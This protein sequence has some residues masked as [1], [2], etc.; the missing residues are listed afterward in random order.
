MNRPP[1][2]D[3]LL[4]LGLRNASISM[5][6]LKR[7]PDGIWRGPSEGSV[8]RPARNGA[9]GRFTV[10]PDDVREEVAD[11]LANESVPDGFAFRLAVRRSRDLNGSMGHQ[12]PTVRQRN[13]YNPLF[14][15]PRDM[16]RLGIE[17]GDWVEIHSEVASIVAIAAADPALRQGVVSMS[18]N[19][20][21]VDNDPAHYRQHGASVNFLIRNDRNFQTINAMPRMSAIPVNVARLQAQRGIEPLTAEATV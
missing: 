8:V 17:T 16:A 10:L 18:H 6:D 14:I 20:G 21:Y 4:G 7:Q 15:S 12:T 5:D 2:S 3:D 9:N 1:T 13:P 11:A 19:W